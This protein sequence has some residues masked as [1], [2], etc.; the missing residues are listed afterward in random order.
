M[1]VDVDANLAAFLRYRTPEAR[2][3]SFDYCFNYFQ[4]AASQET[5]RGWLIVST[6]CFR[7]SNSA[8]FSRAGA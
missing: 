8:S 3:A 7:A 4:E 5:P 2:Y 1:T 6:A